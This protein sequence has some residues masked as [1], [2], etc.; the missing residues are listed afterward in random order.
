MPSVG[1]E[2]SCTL[3]SYNLYPSLRCYIFF[4]ISINLISFGL[5]EYENFFYHAHLSFSLIQP[6]YSVNNILELYIIHQ[7]CISFAECHDQL[8]FFRFYISLCLIPTVFLSFSIMYLPKSN[9]VK[10]QLHFIVQRKGKRKRN[11]GKI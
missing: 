11:K 5:I 1:F 7:V 10:L 6:F 8:F 9:V 4:S 3:N 2:G